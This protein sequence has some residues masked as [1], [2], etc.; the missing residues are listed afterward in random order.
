M[1]GST[2]DPVHAEGARVLEPGAEVVEQAAGIGSAS[3]G[4][5]AISRTLA[6]SHEA[7][8]DR[9]VVR[10]G[11][12]EHLVLVLAAG[13]V[14]HPGAGVEAGADDG[15]LVG[16]HRH[17]AP[18]RRAPRRRARG[19]RVW[20]ASRRRASARPLLDSAPRS[21]TWAPCATWTRP[22]RIA[23]SAGPVDALA[24]GRV[25]GEVDAAHQRRRAVADRHGSRRVRRDDRRDRLSHDA[26]CPACEGRRD[27]AK[28]VSRLSSVA[29]R[30]MAVSDPLD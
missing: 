30:L 19:V 12:G 5:S 29:G 20:S 6:G 13:H 27:P 7:E 17:H 16:L 9:G 11:E 1:P 10:R 4:T 21:T 15:R 18:R 14:E 23:A 24:V 2:H 3:G 25:A 22:L 8:H 28:L 26:P